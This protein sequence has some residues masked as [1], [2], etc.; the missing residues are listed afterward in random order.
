DHADPYEH[1][2]A[3]S[4]TLTEPIN[5]LRH[6][7][8]QN[9]GQVRGLRHTRTGA[10]T[11]GALYVDPLHHDRVDLASRVRFHRFNLADGVVVGDSAAAGAPDS[12]QRRWTEAALSS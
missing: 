10:A 8:L 12:E 4:N 11:I 1:L 9:A 6:A 7:L 3:M 5:S 2:V